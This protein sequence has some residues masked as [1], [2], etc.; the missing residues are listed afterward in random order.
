MRG[1]IFGT[2]LIALLAKVDAV[3][4]ISVQFSAP[5]YWYAKGLNGDPDIPEDLRFL[6]E[7]IATVSHKS[8]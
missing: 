6:K 4:T 3:T 2:L 7:P 5:G 1:K 8:K